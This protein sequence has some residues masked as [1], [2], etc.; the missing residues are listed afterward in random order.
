MGER[1]KEANAINK[2]LSHL[3]CVPLSHLGLVMLKLEEAAGKKRPPGHDSLGG[4]SKTTMIACISLAA[5][6]H[7]ESLS[8]L[9]F[10]QRAKLVWNNAVVNEAAKG[11]Q[12]DQQE[13]I[14]RLQT[15]LH[16]MR[17]LCT[18]GAHLLLGEGLATVEE[19]GG[20]EEQQEGSGLD[21]VEK[22]EKICSRQEGFN[23]FLRPFLPSLPSLPLPS[24]PALPPLPSLPPLTFPPCPPSPTFPPFHP[25]PPSPFPPP[26]YLPSLL[27]LPSLTSLPF[28]FLLAHQETSMNRNLEAAFSCANGL[29][30]PLST[31]GK[32]AARR[33]E[34][35]G[36]EV[37]GKVADVVAAREERMR[38][39]K[40]VKRAVEERD[41][42]ARKVEELE[43]R[44]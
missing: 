24:V 31:R 22:G 29:D 18:R 1:L 16:R 35:G 20:E 4:N 27:S 10:V 30:T 28:P 13:K 39:G 23:E 17:E 41:E 33:G 12:E 37:A 32:A 44:V 36:A 19:G 14:D 26:F 7:D 11:Q 9:R 25:S 42:L 15:E 43:E 3:G 40:E 21:A 6:S 38:E 5:G 8:T 2:S 34:A